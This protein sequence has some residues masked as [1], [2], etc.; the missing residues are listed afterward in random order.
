MDATRFPQLDRVQTEFQALKGKVAQK[1]RIR[2]IRYQE[3][4]LENPVTLTTSALEEKQCKYRMSRCTETL[5]NMESVKDL[6][7]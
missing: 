7:I 3:S 4:A 6:G 5:E 2:E 1:R